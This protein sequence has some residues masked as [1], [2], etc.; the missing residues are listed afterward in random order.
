MSE[1]PP[2]SVTVA[3]G[4]IFAGRILPG[5]KAIREHLG[6]SLQEALLT[7]HER[8]E[9]LQCEQPETFAVAPD[10]YWTGFYS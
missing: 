5:I 1:T 10:E 8:Y 2:A 9:V 6:C 4:E 3:D 7:F